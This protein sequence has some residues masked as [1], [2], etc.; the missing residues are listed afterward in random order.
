KDSLLCGLLLDQSVFAG[1]GNIVKNEV[2]FNIRM[3]PLTKL[4]QVPDKDWPK[5]AEAVREYCWNFYE[6]KKK[7][8]LRKHWQVYRQRHCPLCES[9]LIPG[10]LGKNERR[11][12]Y[13]SLHQPLYTKIRKM[14]VR[15]VLALKSDSPSAPQERLD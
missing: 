12:F 6:W 13:C 7:F 3:H 4:T 14:Q 1:S 5:L 10:P 15:E 11:T 2:L 9:K 8:E